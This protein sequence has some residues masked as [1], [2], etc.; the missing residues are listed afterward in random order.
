M[1][2]PTTTDF[3]DEFRRG[4]SAAWDASDLGKKKTHSLFELYVF[5][6]ILQAAQSQGARIIYKDG[7]GAQYS[8]P[9]FRTGPHQIGDRGYV[10]AELIFSPR[11]VLEVHTGVKCVGKSG[12]EHECDIAVLRRGTAQ[13]CRKESKSPK[14]RQI[15]VSVECKFYLANI[16]LGMSREFVGLTSDLTAPNKQNIYVVSTKI[17]DNGKVL[18]K[19]HQKKAQDELVPSAI[20][21]RDDLL[22]VFEDIFEPYS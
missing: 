14:H 4:L 12:I 15:V 19:H 17:V 20:S 7:N 2:K 9:I 5:K 10:Y 21:K 11:R 3:L 8:M 1:S 16:R 13:R 18:L 6:I 22:K